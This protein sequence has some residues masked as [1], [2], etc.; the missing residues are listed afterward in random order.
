MVKISGM[1]LGVCLGAGAALSLTSPPVG[2][3]AYILGEA[4]H[5]PTI[6]IANDVTPKGRV[7]KEPRLDSELRIPEAPKQVAMELPKQTKPAHLR[8]RKLPVYGQLTKPRVDFDNER[9]AVAR[10][11][12][13][14]ASDFMNRVFI[15]ANDDRF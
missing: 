10:A 13:P 7:L 6:I 12:E 3:R 4:T 11:D 2:K 1:I 8:F 15:P 5:K 9:L 14:V